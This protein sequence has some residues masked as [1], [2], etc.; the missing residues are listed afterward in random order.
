LAEL[1]RGIDQRI[2]AGVAVTLTGSGAGVGGTYSWDGGVI[3]GVSFTPGATTTY[4]LTG[5]NADGC[6][7]TDNVLITVTPFPAV[8]AGTD[9]AIC[10]GDMITLTATGAGMGGT[11]VWDGG[12]VNGVPFIP[13]MTATYTVIGSNATGCESTDMV[14]V[15]VN[16]LPNVAFIG[17]VLAGCAPLK[18]NFTNLVPGSTYAW[19][20]GD[21]S[22]STMENPTHTF[23]SPGLFDVTLTVTSGAGCST[24]ITYDDYINVTATPIANFSFNPGELDILNTTTY[25]NNTSSYASAYEWSFGDGTNSGLENPYHTYPENGN[26]TYEI[27]LIASNEY[28]CADTLVKFIEVKDVLIY[29][30]PNTFTPDGDSFNDSFKPIF[31]SGLD[32]YDFH[33]MIFNRWGEM[34]FESYN[35]AYGW[36][37]FY[38]SDGLVQDG[39]YIW[40]MEFGETMSDKTH[41]VDGHVT[42]IK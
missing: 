39:V 4:T 38:G 24:T 1:I 32:V 20:F 31:A 10:Q 6:E 42:V 17:D 37:G 9:L 36:N 7:N 22:T 26:V 40:R 3:D 19:N 25:F 34:V 14:N 18:T 33:L 12:V 2:C 21:G 11:Y 28:E 27:T 5:A 30:V 13:L 15:T 8:N 35:A 23:T 16:P 29:Y 41:K